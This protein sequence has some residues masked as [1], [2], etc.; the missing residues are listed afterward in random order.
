MYCTDTTYA[1]Q[2]IRPYLRYCITKLMVSRGSDTSL[3]YI[4]MSNYIDAL[5]VH[6][7]D[8]YSLDMFAL[9]S[10]RPPSHTL[11]SL[12]RI[13][14]QITHLLEISVGTKSSCRP[15]LIRFV[16]LNLRFNEVASSHY[17]KIYYRST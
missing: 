13:G 4:R 9:Y 11:I 16:I 12:Q 10:H 7:N 14:N 5:Y 3:I 2:T 1:S 8:K 15:L 6:T 17:S